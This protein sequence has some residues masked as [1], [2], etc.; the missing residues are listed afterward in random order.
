[1]EKSATGIL[2]F[3][4][5]SMGGLPSGRTTLL[6]GGP[7]S[8]KTVFAL[9]TLVYG[10]RECGHPGI[11]VAFEQ[12]PA[13]VKSDAAS[14]NWK[15]ES[16][17]DDQLTFIDARPK[18][19]SVRGGNFD[20]GGML[21]L[22]EVR[23]SEIDGKIVVFDGIDV[24]LAQ[25]G[26]PDV[27]RREI[28]RLQDWLAQQGLTALITCKTTISDPLFIG[29]PSLEFL[30]YM[31]ACSIILNHDI[32]EDVSQ[33]SLRIAKYRG[34]GFQGNAVPFLIGNGGIELTVLHTPRSM[35]PDIAP[36]RISC[37]V[38]SLDDMLSGGFFRTACVL[39]T[40]LPGTGKTTFCGAFVAAACSRGERAVFVS[41]VSRQEEILNNLKSMSI[42]LQPFVESGML[43]IVATRASI[44]SPETHLRSI[45][46]IAQ[47]HD[48][49]CIVIDPMSALTSFVNTRPSPGLTERL[50]DWAKDDRRTLVC[51]GLLGDPEE[52][53]EPPALQIATIADTWIHLNNAEQGH[54]R[55]RDLAIIKSRGTGHSRQVR[56]F[57]LSDTGINLLNGREDQGP[58]DDSSPPRPNFQ[59][60]DPLSLQSTEKDNGT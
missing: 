30:Q 24:L 40:G 19:D 48:A 10:A 46:S 27:I 35:V 3:D 36:E 52:L 28:H 31:V 4:D 21:A 33:R 5:I 56:A 53:I 51:T 47:K 16:L 50:I 44:G 58:S 15:Q 32:V 34:S 22:L 38:P 60:D 9:Q 11:F 43:Q 2:G 13:T 6:T 25:M 26:D 20:I 14:F 45:R 8:G 54:E 7:G 18:H 49:A 41:F 37:G 39:L 12:D 59:Q 29:L 55:T 1:M 17:S 42:D 23:I 57:V